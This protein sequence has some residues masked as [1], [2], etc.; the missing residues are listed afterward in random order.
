[1]KKQPNPE[2]AE[3]VRREVPC[4]EVSPD[5]GLT[6]AQARELAELGYLKSYGARKPE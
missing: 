1:M 4:P 3:P 5:R 6:S 2:Q